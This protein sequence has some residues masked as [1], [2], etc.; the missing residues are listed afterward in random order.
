MR[1]KLTYIALAFLMTLGAS[2]GSIFVSPPVSASISTYQVCN[3][4]ASVTTIVAWSSEGQFPDTY[5][6]KGQCRNPFNQSGVTSGPGISGVRVDVDPDDCC[7]LDVDSYYIG[8]I[9]QG[10]G[11]CHDSENNASDPPDNA[12]QGVRYNTNAGHC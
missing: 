12:P 11:P 10:Y 4:S 1:K 3:S 2:V 9:G 6:N 7:G 5:L 8:V